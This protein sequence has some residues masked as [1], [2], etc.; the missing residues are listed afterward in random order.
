MAAVG[1]RVKRRI[2]REWVGKEGNA[3]KGEMFLPNLHQWQACL[4]QVEAQ[5][6]LNVFIAVAQRVNNMDGLTF[7]QRQWF[8]FEFLQECACRFIVLLG[9]EPLARGNAAQVGRLDEVRQP[10]RVLREGAQ[11]R[12]VLQAGEEGFGRQSERQ[13]LFFFATGDQNDRQGKP[14]G[15]V[16]VFCLQDFAYALNQ[17]GV[18]A[19]IGC[20][21]HR[22]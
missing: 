6:R 12:V 17:A 15:F 7:G 4:L 9:L 11:V 5:G 19:D 13:G 18:S 1:K 16:I 2:G 21:G 22:Q 20:H 3:F 14:L 8:V 10:L